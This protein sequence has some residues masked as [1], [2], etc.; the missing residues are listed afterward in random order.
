MLKILC[1]ATAALGLVAS[2]QAQT[3]TVQAGT[4]KLEPNH[5]QV[6]FGVNHLGFS[7]Y[8]GSFSGA[9]GSLTLDPA[10]PAASKLDISVPVASV[11]TPS[12]K[13]TGELKSA[14]WLGADEF[15][16]MTFHSTS[17]TPTGPTSADIAG[18]LTLHGVTKPVT[19]KAKFHGAG[20]NPIT[21]AYTIGFDVTGAVKRSDFGVSTYVPMISDNVDLIITAAFEK[22][23]G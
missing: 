8:Y 16:T 22:T 4:Y 9:S 7:N 2:A 19:L 20:P 23:A 11:Y 14:G 17:V 13:L 5:T 10:K 3:P 21:K 6:F 12:D 18:D 1:V 15:P